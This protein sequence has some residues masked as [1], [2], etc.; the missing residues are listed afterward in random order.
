[1]SSILPTPSNGYLISL[2][3][4]LDPP[5]LNSIFGSIH[6]R[7][8]E[9]EG[10]IVDWEAAV[11][12]LN[13]LGLQVIAENLEPQLQAAR[14]QLADLQAQ[15]DALADQVAALIAAGI[16]ASG[17]TVTPID[18]LTATTVQAALVE[19]LGKIGTNATAITTLATSTT[20]ALAAKAD[21]S[22]LTA[23][24]A[25]SATV[26]TGPVA[27]VAGGEYFVKTGGGPVTLPSAPVNGN[28]VTV[29]RYGTSNV[30][31]ARNGKTINGLTEDLTIDK[32][33]MIATLKYM[34]SGW[35]AVPGAF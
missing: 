16:F 26:V 9:L 21:T 25:G 22:A 32:D 2:D 30:T 15:A 5:N 3:T 31:V 18:G 35:F 7:L 33:R 27:A 24:G 29:W 1:M 10:Q 12:N 14:D 23:L 11:D 20:A 4:A 19:L 13:N 28:V 8:G 6:T 17:V 34:D